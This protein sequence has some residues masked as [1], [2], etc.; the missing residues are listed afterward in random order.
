VNPHTSDRVRRLWADARPDLDT[1]PMEVVG[2]LKRIAALFED[3]IA[4]L[5]AD[6]PL[7]SAELDLCVRLRHDTSRT[8]ARHLAG[9]LGHSRAGV[10][11][12]LRRLESRG[13]IRRDPDPAD[14]RA[15]V[16]HLTPEGEAV[17]DELFPRQLA[18]EAKLLAALGNDRERVVQALD[19]L[20]G[21]LGR[22]M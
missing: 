5:Y 19:L 11:K 20:V 21:V 7:T 10:S 15:A 9:H 4:P 3:A 16:V 1:S 12:T 18:V 2:P 8:I 22:E 17:T 14:R 13:L 6:A